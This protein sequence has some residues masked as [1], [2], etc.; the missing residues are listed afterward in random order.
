[1]ILVD[2][3][4]WVDHLR[5]DNIDLTA[6]LGTGMVLAH[7]FVIGELALGNL[8]QRKAILTA[9]SDLPHADIATDAEVL[10]FIDRHAL[11]G[12]GVGYVDAHLLAAVRLTAGA[13]LWTNDRRLHGVAD[14][15]GLATAPLRGL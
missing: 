2:T 15:L 8:R 4:V 12:R 1:V 10:T 13:T 11:S 7:P 9:L 14:E 3:S 6:M 5:A